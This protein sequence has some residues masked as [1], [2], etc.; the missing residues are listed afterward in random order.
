MDGCPA[1]IDTQIVSNYIMYMV[2]TSTHEHT[3]RVP[4]KHAGLMTAIGLSISINIRGTL[5]Y[6]PDVTST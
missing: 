1:E 3:T 6:S 2:R 4:N 5:V